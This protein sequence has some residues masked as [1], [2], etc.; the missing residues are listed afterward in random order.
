MLCLVGNIGSFATKVCKFSMPRQSTG[1]EYFEITTRFAELAIR[2]CSLYQRPD[3]FWLH[4][5]WISGIGP[6]WELVG[7]VF[8]C[9]IFRELVLSI[10]NMQHVFSLKDSQ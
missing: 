6:G 3:Q 4:E 5:M 1:L 7:D 10:T 9:R 2:K 8:T